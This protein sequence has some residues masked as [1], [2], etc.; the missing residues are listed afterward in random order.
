MAFTASTVKWMKLDRG[1]KR[2]RKGAIYIYIRIQRENE[3]VAGL[4]TREKESVA[5]KEGDRRRKSCSQG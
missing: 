3:R 1:G 5:A 4:K 2:G